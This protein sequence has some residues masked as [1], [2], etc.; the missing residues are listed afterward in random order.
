MNAASQGAVIETV[1]EFSPFH[2][3]GFS[4]G[5][6]IVDVD[7]H[8]VRDL[9]DWR[10]LTDGLEIEVGYVDT[11]GDEGRALV[12]R[13][14]GEAWGVG[15]AEAIFDEVKQCRN[16]CTFCFMRM[17]PDGMRPSLSLRDDDYRLSFLQGNFVTF[18]NLG[19]ADEA[20]IVE[21][22]LSPLRFS[23]HAVDADVRRRVIG[24]HAQ[25]GL[26]VAQRLMDAG[27]ELHAQI[28]LMPHVN[29]CAVLEE[30]L[31]WAYAH[32]L[33]RTVG[34]VP[35]GY[36]KHQ[37]TFTESFG[38]VESAQS[39]L[40]SVE[41]FACRARA[42]RGFDWVFC[43]DEFYRNAYP[44]SLLEHLPS[45]ERYGSFDMFEDGIGIIRS[46]VDDW[47][48]CTALQQHAAEVLT[49]ANCRVALVCGC[50]QR[51]FL[52]PLLAAS[53]LSGLIVPLYVE[54]EHFGGNVDVTGLLCASDMV[55]ALKQHAGAFA[56][57]AIPK[58]VFN[59]KGMT[60]DDV[61]LAQIGLFSG[62]DVRMVSCQAS[63]Y[64]GEIAQAIEQE[65][66]SRG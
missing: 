57:A 19:A 61:N 66:G 13:D 8:P 55:P 60:L 24:K 5:C 33:I 59:D 16:A 52:D 32:P 11:D 47:Q 17:L 38:S 14:E 54:N 64:V 4:P 50:A 23:L 18:T 12:S 65:R 25:A 15:F 62:M 21:Q 44:Q 45:A 53:P 63:E 26:D 6:R 43:S 34:I 22:H 35:V 10:W 58:V 36:T 28:V 41:P 20:R 2:D 40:A 27:I 46:F 3:A 39:V 30:T 29:D 31:A 42:E 48:G 7:G 1:D 37:S 56:F 9:I 49:Q 51:E